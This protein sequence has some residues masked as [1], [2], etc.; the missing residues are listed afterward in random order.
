MKSGYLVF[1]FACLLLFQQGAYGGENEQWVATDKDQKRALPNV[2]SPPARLVPEHTLQPL[3]DLPL[4][5]VRCVRL[6]HDEKLV[7]L[8]FDLCE[9]ATSTT[10]CDVAVLNYLRER[11]IPAT[12]FMGGKWMRTHAERVR[13]ILSYN[14][15]FEI[16]NHAWSHGNFALLTEKAAT[17]QVLWTQAQYELLR[18]SLPQNEKIPPV[19][20]LF[21]LPYGRCNDM[22]LKLLAGLGLRVIQWDIVAER[23]LD[24]LNAE[25]ARA[26]GKRVASQ[27]RPGSIILFHANCVPKGTYNLLKETVA[28][29]QHLGYS[30]VTVGSLLARGEPVT[31]PD[32]Y[33]E[34]PGDNISLDSKFGIDGTGQRK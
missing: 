26:E 31:T 4:G 25:K 34:Q 7:A 32:G 5:T 28:A 23:G 10:G 2:M 20:K 6:Q 1:L 15:L 19:P 29:L 17:E 12:L 24:S 3:H 11:R 22:S 13:Q 18:E 8:T 9:L 27:C 33:F 14:D 30:F 16:G 21:R